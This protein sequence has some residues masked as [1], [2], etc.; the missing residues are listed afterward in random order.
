MLPRD[1]GNRQPPSAAGRTKAAIVAALL[2]LDVA[3]GLAPLAAR[4]VRRLW[5]EFKVS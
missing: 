4:A 2:V 3:P 1:T 5:A